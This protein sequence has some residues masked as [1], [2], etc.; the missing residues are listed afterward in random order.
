[1]KWVVFVK[2]YDK[3]THCTHTE[4]GLLDEKS[5]QDA[6]ATASH[7]LPKSI[8]LYGNVALRESVYAYLADEKAIATLRN[9]EEI[10]SK[11]GWTQSSANEKFDW[12]RHRKIRPD[13]PRERLSLVQRS[14]DQKV[15]HVTGK[16]R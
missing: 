15:R 7:V 12:A 5:R 4:K 2:Y 11:H 14:R 1:M 9:L 10:F 6:Y 13:D 8:K 3:I 16:D